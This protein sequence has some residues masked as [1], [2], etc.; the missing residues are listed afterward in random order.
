MQTVRYN[1]FNLIH[2]GLRAMC[3]QTAIKLQQADFSDKKS[4]TEVI[5]QLE[6]LLD[7]FTS[8]AHHEDHLILPAVSAFAPALADIFE[9]EHIKDEQIGQQVADAIVS[10][11][12]ATTSTEQVQAGKQICYCFYDFVAFNLEHMNKEERLLNVALWDNYSD[13]ELLVIQQK[14]LGTIPPAELMEQGRWIA[15]GINADEAVA[16]AA[17]IKK[18]ALPAVQDQF[19]KVL[20]EEIHPTQYVLIEQ[21]LANPPSA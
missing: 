10:W 5:L 18:T 20:K 2:K 13:Q 15:R 8:H 12:T 7:Y 6:T 1:M 19:F 21:R 11:K 3:Y 16:W 9:N 14:L 4:A 17:G